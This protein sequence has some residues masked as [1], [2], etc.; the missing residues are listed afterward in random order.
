MNFDSRCKAKTKRGESCR[1][2]ATEGGLCF[3]HANPNKAAELG[4]IGGQKK[5][6]ARAEA[7]APL[8]TLDNAVATCT[9]WVVRFGWTEDSRYGQFHADDF[10]N[11]GFR[12]QPQWK[13]RLRV[14]SK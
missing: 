12:F 4:R 1:A 10:A 9:A 14:A 3:F 5:G 13:H 6:Q 11:A 7:A 8:P 2:A